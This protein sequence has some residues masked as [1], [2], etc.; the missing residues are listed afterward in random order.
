[1]AKG[2][3]DENG[4]YQDP[5]KFCPLCASELEPFA[6]PEA[7]PAETWAHPKHPECEW[8]EYE[9]MTNHQIGGIRAGVSRKR[10]HK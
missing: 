3:V 2:Y 7:G 10:R 5:P 1:M 6:G 4:Q 9:N 8:S